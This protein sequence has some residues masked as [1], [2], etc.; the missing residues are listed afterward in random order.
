MRWTCR[1]GAAGALA[2][3]LA[4]SSVAAAQ[5][6]EPS[7]LTSAV[8]LCRANHSRAAEVLAAADSAGWRVFPVPAMGGMAMQGR[9][10]LIDGKPQT[11]AVFSLPLAS[12]GGAQAVVHA[13]QVNASA[14]VADLKMAVQGLMGGRAPIDSG[15][16]VE[17]IF[18]ERD[19]RRAFLP[20]DAP[21]TM[22]AALKTGPVWILHVPSHGLTVMYNEVV[23]TP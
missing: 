9:T 5:V 4:L 15:N 3:A 11:L 10:K 13:C 20:D 12:D 17:W 16:F 23:A 21:A 22:T 18:T 7:I 1:S 14:P 6:A 2:V 8:T 19:G